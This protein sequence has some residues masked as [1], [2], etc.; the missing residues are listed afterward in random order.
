MN[1]L[2]FIGVGGLP[3]LP[4]WGCLLPEFPEDEPYGNFS[5]G[6]LLVPTFMTA[7]WVTVFGNTALYIEL[8]GTGGLVEAVG[9]NLAVAL[10]VLL[11]QFPLF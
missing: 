11:E 3:G 8:F 1:G 2:Y 9:S 7:V 5:L 10:F 6:V 4:S